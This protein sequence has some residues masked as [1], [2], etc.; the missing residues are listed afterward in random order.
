MDELAT[1]EIASQGR[2]A[3]AWDDYRTRRRWCY[4]NV[5]GG[6]VALAVILRL[7]EVVFGWKPARELAPLAVVWAISSTATSAR[8]GL[9]PCPRC[10]RRFSSRARYFGMRTL[11]RTT[12]AHCGLPLWANSPP[13]QA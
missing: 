7:W 11:P 3:R 4:I 10:G 13:G 9:W 1:S 6:V 12:C 5:F 2:Y 8:L